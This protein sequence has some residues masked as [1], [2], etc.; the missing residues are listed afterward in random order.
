MPLDRETVAREAGSCGVAAMLM[1]I[2]LVL[3]DGRDAAAGEIGEVWLKGPSVTPG[4]WNQPEATAKAF[5]GEWFRTGDAATCSADGFY[6]IVDRWKDMYISGGENVYP[7]EV[8]SILAEH[9]AIAEAAVVGVADERWGESGCA[10]VVARPN[11][12]I[13]AVEIVNH[14]SARLARYK[15]PRHVRFVDMLPRTASG[16]VR[17]DELRRAFSKTE[18]VT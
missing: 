17:K 8:E 1:D 13:A 6:R 10:F 15:V 18:S 16:K 2:R 14:C 3:P 11:A 4:Y 5:H 7:A 12:S 9:T